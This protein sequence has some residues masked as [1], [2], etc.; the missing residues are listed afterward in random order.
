MSAWEGKGDGERET[1][2]QKSREVCGHGW[3]YLHC[4]SMNPHNASFSLFLLFCGYISH[5]ICTQEGHLESA[6]HRRI[7]AHTHT[8]T[9]QGYCSQSSL[10]IK[11]YPSFTHKCIHAK[12]ILVKSS[13]SQHWL[14]FVVAHLHADN[15]SL[16]QEHKNTRTRV[17]SNQLYFSWFLSQGLVSKT[18]FAPKT[19][20]LQMRAW[21]H[22]CECRPLS[23]IPLSFSTRIRLI[24]PLPC[25]QSQV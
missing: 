11:L 9:L 3:G 20:S 21:L 2:R 22:V 19:H 10:I 12:R 15:D 7:C 25:Q 1:C 13:T 8:H 4:G 23:L 5:S 18:T 24:T 17:T 6:T 16:T 14:T